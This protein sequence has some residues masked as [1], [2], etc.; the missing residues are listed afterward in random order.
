MTP[1]PH[2]DW[3]YYYVTFS[4]MIFW[5]LWF[6]YMGIVDQNWLGFVFVCI[7]LSTAVIFAL[8]YQVGV[9]WCRCCREKPKPSTPPPP[10]QPQQHTIAGRS[11]YHINSSPHQV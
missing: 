1:E 11:L 7:V 8:C 9:R 4:G 6:L 2:R 5:A 10:P 3:H